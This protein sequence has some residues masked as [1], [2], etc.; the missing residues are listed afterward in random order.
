MSLNLW[1]WRKD[2]SVSRYVDSSVYLRVLMS[3][4]G[5]MTLPADGDWYTS[6]LTRVEGRRMLYRL[7][8]K[9]KFDDAELARLL[10]AL[11]ALLASIKIVPCDQ[12]ILDRS[13]DPMNAPLG[14]LDAIHLA[15]ALQVQSAVGEKVR[16]YT[17]NVELAI[18]ARAAGLEP[19]TQ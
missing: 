6:V 5:A 9:G 18:A 12:T 17:H 11:D 1:R 3:H 15:S 13:G 2:R 8:G 4:A 16:L 7:H 19:V 10:A 14:S